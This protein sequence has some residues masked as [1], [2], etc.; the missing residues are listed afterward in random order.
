M[1][2]PLR[3]LGEYAELPSRDQGGAT[4]EQVA[5]ALVTVGLE[6][7]ALHG[8]DVRGPVVVGRVLEFTDEP[9]KNGKTI[10]WCQVDVG[11]YN[12]DGEKARGIVCGAHNFVDG[13]LVVVAHSVDQLR[14]A[15]GSS[16]ARSIL[17]S[18]PPAA[19]RRRG[20]LGDTL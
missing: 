9:Q 2:V 20:D 10:R 12:P 5:A 18:T 8:G 7:E 14:A 19:A 17:R 13:D 16:C 3:W 15:M 4:G 6:E 1:R 11:P